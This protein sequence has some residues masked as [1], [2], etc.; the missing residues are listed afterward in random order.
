MRTWSAGSRTGSYISLPQNPIHSPHSWHLKELEWNIK[1]PSFTGFVPIT[2]WGDLVSKSDCFPTKSLSQNS[3]IAASPFSCLF[4]RQPLNKPSLYFL[5]CLSWFSAFLHVCC[6]HPG[7]LSHLDYY[8][9]SCLVFA[10]FCHRTVREIFTKR[11]PRTCRVPHSGPWCAWHHSHTP[12]PPSK[13]RVKEAPSSQPLPTAS[14][15]ISLLWSH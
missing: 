10:P 2:D 15:L 5:Q 11:E 7:V 6:H 9:H 13:Q 8:N 4:R 12:Y 1:L 14:P 3:R